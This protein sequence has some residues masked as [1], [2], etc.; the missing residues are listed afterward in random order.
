MVRVP[1]EMIFDQLTSYARISPGRN[2]RM[3]G[4]RATAAGASS[5]KTLEMGASPKARMHKMTNFRTTERNAIFKGRFISNP[6][7]T[8]GRGQKG[9][10]PEALLILIYNKIFFRTLQEPKKA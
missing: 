6:I 9:N 8:S 5:L 2:A 3:C 10:E 4:G 1:A 7:R